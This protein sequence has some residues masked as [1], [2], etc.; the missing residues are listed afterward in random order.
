VGTA[1]S[2]EVFTVHDGLHEGLPDGTG[3]FGYICDGPAALE[4]SAVDG[5][6]VGVRGA[7]IPPGLRLPRTVM[8]RCSTEEAFMIDPWGGVQAVEGQSMPAWMASRLPAEA[9]TASLEVEIPDGYVWLIY[10]TPIRWSVRALVEA[11]EM[12]G[13]RPAAADFQW[14]YPVLRAA[15]R[16]TV[17]AWLDYVAAAQEIAGR[18]G[19]A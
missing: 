10:R 11:A 5:S 17:P 18:R 8:V 7:K 9:C 12:P 4:V 16:C 14:A 6:N 19:T 2:S 13:P 15:D 1:L 3:A